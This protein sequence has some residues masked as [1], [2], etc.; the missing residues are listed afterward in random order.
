MQDDDNYDGGADHG[1]DHYVNDDDDGKRE[2][3][4]SVSEYGCGRDCDYD[5]AGVFTMQLLCLCGLIMVAFLT[6]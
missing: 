2:V 5:C 6:M 4:S 1:G 3:Y